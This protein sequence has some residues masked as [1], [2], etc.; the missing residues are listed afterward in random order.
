MLVCARYHRKLVGVGAG[1]LVEVALG[2]TGFEV[3]V[4]FVG[5]GIDL[6]EVVHGEVVLVV[7]G[8]VVGVAEVGVVGVV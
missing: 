1:G 2:R 3:G 8:V 6:G 5:E 7:V 4:A